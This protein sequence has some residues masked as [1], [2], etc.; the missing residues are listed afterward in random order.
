ML[1]RIVIYQKCKC[2]T[3]IHVY[4]SH[5]CQSQRR[6]VDNDG[7]V[8]TSDQDKTNCYKKDIIIFS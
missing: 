4:A 3:K 2:D 1:K 7:H 6:S 8:E 5:L